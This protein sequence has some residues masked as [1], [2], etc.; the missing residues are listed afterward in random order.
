[1]LFC[2]QACEFI[3]NERKYVEKFGFILL[4]QKIINTRTENYK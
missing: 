2:P 4:E 1:M 3:F